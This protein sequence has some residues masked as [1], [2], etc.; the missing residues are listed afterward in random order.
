MSENLQSGRTADRYN[1]LIG[2]RLRRPGETWFT[3]RISDLSVGGFR[4]Q[5]FIKLSAGMELWIMLPGFEGRKATVT[6]ARDHEAG[7]AFERP[8]HA[9]ILDHIVRTSGT[10]AGGLA[11]TG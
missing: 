5:S 9:A 6:W 2:V 11:Q 1:V 3:S 8:L 7:C 10:R 4:L